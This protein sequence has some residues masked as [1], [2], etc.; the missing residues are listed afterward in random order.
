MAVDENR[1]GAV[2]GPEPL[3]INSRR[4]PGAVGPSSVGSDHLYLM[5]PGL[6]Q[7]VG[8][9]LRRVGDVTGVGRVGGNGRDPEPIAQRGEDAV[10]G[11]F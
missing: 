5:E 10:L 3:A 11:T 8:T 9:E 2:A 4:E 7:L 1:G 6:P